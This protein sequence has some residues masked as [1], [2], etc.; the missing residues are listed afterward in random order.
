MAKIL[1]V[2]D[3]PTETYKL[4]NILERS[5]HLVLSAESGEQGINLA[6]SE[7]PD[8]VLMDIVMPGLNGFQA[9]RQLS[10]GTETKHIPVIIV[11]AKNQQADQVW[12]ER[13]GARAYLVKPIDEKQL[14]TA[15]DEVLAKRSHRMSEGKE[16]FSV[17][18]EA[19]QRFGQSDY[20]LPAQKKIA[21]TE[22]LIG[23]CLFD[24]EYVVSLS[25]ISEVLEVPKCT[26]LPRV[27]PWVLGSGECAR[28]G[29]CR[30]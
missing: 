6:K 14:V 26:K 11:T 12:G 4:T 21:E 28:A 2:D 24:M 15:I 16:I 8:V 18:S 5:D 27:K 25:D 17:I 23:F 20:G 30:S 3:S 1:I 19:V 29:Y 13:Q 9:T 22:K 10:R 7:Q